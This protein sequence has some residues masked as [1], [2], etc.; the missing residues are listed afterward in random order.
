MRILDV[1]GKEELAK[2][3]IAAMR[4]D[5]RHLVEFVESTQPPIPRDKK[6]V[7]IVSSLFGCPVK[8]RM[9]DAGGT[10]HGKLDCDEILEQIDFMVRR[11]FPDGVIPVPK[12]KIQFARMGEPSLNPNVL[13]ALSR[14]HDIYDAPGL[15]PSLSSVAPKSS[16]DF[17]D[18]LIEIKDSYYPKGRFQ[19]QFSIHTTDSAKRDELIPLKKWSFEEIAEYGARFH[20]KG[21]K[22]LT[23]N[24]AAAKGYEVDPKVAREYFDPG[25]FLIKLTPLNPTVRV[26]ESRLESAIDPYDTSSASQIVD[27][28]KNQGFDVILSIGEVE[29]NK[30]GSNCGQ[31]VTQFRAAQT[32]I[33]EGYETDRYQISSS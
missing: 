24:F 15:L 27:G 26:E 32:R 31:F 33:K 3:Y 9:C 12:F 5:D 23:L 21:D 30:I 1:Y 14:L 20:K 16:R 11:R 17:F 10:F 18:H 13:K 4:N 7:L 8:C 6:W 28:F 29:E 22:K 2:V 19:L 25:T